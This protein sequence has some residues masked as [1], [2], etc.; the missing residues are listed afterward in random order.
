VPAII[1]DFKAIG[2]VLRKQRAD[3]WWQPAKSGP[4]PKVGEPESNDAW[5]DPFAQVYWP[6]NC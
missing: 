2:G 4:E 1:H 3:D 6:P 5:Y